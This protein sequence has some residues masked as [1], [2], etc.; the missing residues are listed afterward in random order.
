MRGRKRPKRLTILVSCLDEDQ[1]T[2]QL[3]PLGSEHELRSGD[4]FR[5]EVE[6]DWGESIEVSHFPD[7]IS[8]W[9]NTS[10]DVRVTNSAGKELPL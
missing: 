1:V 8:V 7:R 3:E 2:I 5:V 10:A 9:I 4:H 6:G